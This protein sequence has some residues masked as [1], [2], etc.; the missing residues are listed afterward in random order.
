M[1]S[2]IIGGLALALFAY[3]TSVLGGLATGIVCVLDFLMGLW[4]VCS[5]LWACSE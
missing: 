1:L 4:V 3:K 5:C 2:P